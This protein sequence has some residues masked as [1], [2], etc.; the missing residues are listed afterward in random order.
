MLSLAEI[1]YREE[2]FDDLAYLVPE[3][4]KLANVAQAS[5]KQKS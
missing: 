2:R 1:R 3:Y 4:G 5:T